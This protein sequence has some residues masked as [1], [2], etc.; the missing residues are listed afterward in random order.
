MRD[1]LT[2]TNTIERRKK[3]A[4]DS[5]WRTIKA[6]WER[7]RFLAVNELLKDNRF[8]KSPK[9]KWEGEVRIDKDAVLEELER[10]VPTP[11]NLDFERMEVV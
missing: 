5:M 2:G 4:P 10:L 8:K 9:S 11:E 3:R 7:K 1:S 6:S